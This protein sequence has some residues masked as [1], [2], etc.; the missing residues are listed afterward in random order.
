MREL[1]SKYFECSFKR[2]MFLPTAPDNYR[3]KLPTY[4]HFPPGEILNLG[5]EDVLGSA[6]GSSGFFFFFLLSG[7]LSA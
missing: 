3:D 2:P 1:G 4:S 6:C 7:K 5:F